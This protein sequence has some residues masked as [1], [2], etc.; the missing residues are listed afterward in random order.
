MDVLVVHPSELDWHPEEFVLVFIKGRGE[1]VLMHE[2]EVSAG[3]AAH[4]C[5]VWK[6]LLYNCD[7]VGFASCKLILIFH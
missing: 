7:K 5:K 1:G 3:V 4:S 2:N 6:L